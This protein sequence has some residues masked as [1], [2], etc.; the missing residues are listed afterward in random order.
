MRVRLLFDLGDT[1][2][3]A[4]HFK[5]A[6]RFFLRGAVLG[7]A[8]CCVRLGFLYD[9][10][11]GCKVDKA[12]AMYWY[13][14]G[15]RSRDRCAAANI[16]ILYRERGRYGPMF[17]W[18]GRAAKAGDG[19]AFVELAKCYRSGSGVRR[20]KV[21]AIRFLSTSITLSRYQ[22]TENGREEAEAILAELHAQSSPSQR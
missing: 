3:T 15:W 22:I 11:V 7:D 13:K 20:D 9:T 1:A 4:G 19:D 12:R 16:A 21:A 18:F 10:G 2:E 6:R 14:I 5:V 8:S 17:Y